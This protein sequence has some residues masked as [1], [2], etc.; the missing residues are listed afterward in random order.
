M[1]LVS[2]F[3]MPT[4]MPFSD[5]IRL[6]EGLSVDRAYRQRKKNKKRQLKNR[7]DATHKKGK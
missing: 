1:T 5:F 3:P 2:P 4:H 6:L 7:K